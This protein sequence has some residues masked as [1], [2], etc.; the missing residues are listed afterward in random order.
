[1]HCP[2]RFVLRQEETNEIDGDIMVGV[3]HESCFLTGLR[4]GV[5][6]AGAGVPVQTFRREVQGNV[7][8]RS[9]AQNRAVDFGS[10]KAVGCSRVE[11]RGGAA[12]S[13]AAAFS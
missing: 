6:S 9:R 10:V 13:F 12:V 4:S 5:G 8:A 11:N 7:G 1:M 2:V 3:V